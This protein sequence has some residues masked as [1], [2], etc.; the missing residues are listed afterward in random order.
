MSMAITS[1]NAAAAIR[2]CLGRMLHRLREHIEETQAEQGQKNA[3]LPIPSGRP[4]GS[5]ISI[6]LGVRAGDDD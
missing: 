1:V 2:G 5:L 4:C 6:R 3:A